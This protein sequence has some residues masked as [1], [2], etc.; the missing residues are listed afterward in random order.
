MAGSTVGTLTQVGKR[1]CY[2]LAL[3]LAKEQVRPNVVVLGNAA[4]GLHPVAGQGFNMAARDVAI[5]VQVLDRARRQGQ[6]LGD[7]NLLTGYLRQRSQDQGNT[8]Q[9]SDK[10]TKLF[11]N[12]NPALNLL[13]NSGLILF[14][15]L[16]GTK[17]LVARHAMGRSVST[18][19][20]E[21]AP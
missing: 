9:F 13:R 1:Y 12:R 17:R 4:H 5:L 6:A 2:P 7:F 16:Q 15:S 3:T 8:I 20:P 11:S 19:L 10:L 18:L 14:D 21:P